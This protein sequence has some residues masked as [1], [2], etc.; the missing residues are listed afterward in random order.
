MT[1]EEIK[2]KL[3]VA[4]KDLP[5]AVEQGI[6]H[7]D[8]RHNDPVLPEE[9][10]S[11]MTSADAYAEGANV[12]TRSF[13]DLAIEVIWMIV[14]GD[15]SA[16]RWFNTGTFTGEPFYGVQPNGKKVEFSGMT[17]WRWEDGQVVEGMTLFDSIGFN[18]QING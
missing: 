6:I 18:K 17:M 7:P 8:Y 9:L 12:F 5:A 3:L 16:V 10:I 4:V 2:Q 14:E 15:K 11:T 13:P 1:E